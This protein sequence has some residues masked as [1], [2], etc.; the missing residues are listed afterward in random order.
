MIITKAIRFFKIGVVTL[1]AI[2]IAA[3]VWEAYKK[4]KDKNSNNF[5]KPDSGRKYAKGKRDII[6]ETSWQ[7]FPASDAPASNKFN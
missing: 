5:D 3:A 6:D 4:S 7:S 1:Q 2:T